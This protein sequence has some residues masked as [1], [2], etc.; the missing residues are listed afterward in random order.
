MHFQ[1]PRL[2]NS[3]YCSTDG[4]ESERD[5]IL[6]EDFCSVDSSP[7]GLT[8][9]IARLKMQEQQ[10]AKQQLSPRWIHIKEFLV[11]VCDALECRKMTTH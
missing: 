3:N 10:S 7:P 11:R 4:E 1:A 2:K 9:P 6:L 8:A 5:K